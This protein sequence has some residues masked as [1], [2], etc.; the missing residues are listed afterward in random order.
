[1]LESHPLEPTPENPPLDLSDT[2]TFLNTIVAYGNKGP[3]LHKQF[4]QQGH[5]TL[6]KFDAVT[7]PDGGIDYDIGKEI[8][9]VSHNSYNPSEPSSYRL[10]RTFHVFQKPGDE[11]ST[12]AKVSI[13]YDPKNV[14][15]GDRLKHAALVTAGE[16]LGLFDDEGKLIAPPVSDPSISD[17]HFLTQVIEEANERSK[18]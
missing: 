1:M 4:D 18:K 9:R 7:F 14:T 10:M 2:L 11:T 13:P 16:D 17:I 12:T 15:F 5:F 8:A 6:S 3:I